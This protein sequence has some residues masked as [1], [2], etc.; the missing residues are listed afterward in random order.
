MTAYP[1]AHHPTVAI[2]GSGIA[3]LGAAYALKNHAQVTVFEQNSTLGGHSH[4]IDVTLDNQTWPVDVGFLVFNDRTYPQL[5]ALFSELNVDIA[6][7]EM[8][9]AVSLGPYD[10]EWCGS[11]QLSKALAQPTN[12]FKPRF[13]RMI[14][15]MMRFNKEATALAQQ[16]NAAQALASLS[17]G[18]YLER[19]K[20]SQPFRH[21]YLLPM[22]AA[23][24]SCPV[25]QI[26][27][28]PMHTFV[29]FCDNHGLLQVNNRPRWKT[30]RASSRQYVSKIVA[31]LHASHG[32][33][34]T[35]CKVQAIKRDDQEVQ[36]QVNGAWHS[37]DYVVLAGHSDQSLQLLGDQ[38]TLAETTA[39]GAIA[40]QPNRTVLHTDTRLMP[41]RKRA[42]AAWN[43][44]G[45]SS[46]DQRDQDL[47]VT[48]WSNCLQPLPFKTQV[49]VTLNPVIEPDPLTIISDLNFAHPV[50]NGA[51]IQAQ[52]KI[53][54]LQ[55]L[56]R[57]F[58]AGAWLGYGFHE[59]GLRSGMAA[60][61]LLI[62]R[63]AD[64]LLKLRA[65]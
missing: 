5:I 57:T 28:F 1:F 44:L 59:D 34:L 3:G 31:A 37:F 64:P 36:L 54:D 41:K 26:L 33:V 53:A 2:I 63:Q 29:R 14:K 65:A 35:D 39:L 60:A 23:I 12:A 50:F 18:E 16:A 58:Y 8:S 4:A 47:S 61:D 25:A 32:K 9:F 19:G 48:Y 38:A 55:G 51:A 49:F 52:S 17:L 21:D 40:Y 13:W 7:S 15:D 30:V 24:W 10:Y 6:E 43:Y 42:W 46:N 56:N 20:Y 11:N 22:A 62:A 27:A 45:K